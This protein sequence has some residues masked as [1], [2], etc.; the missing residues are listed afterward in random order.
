[1][2]RAALDEELRSL[3]LARL[4]TG[5]AVGVALQLGFW[6]LDLVVIPERRWLF[7]GLRVGLL[8]VVT[9]AALACRAAASLRA[10]RAWLLVGTLAMGAVVTTMTVFL[11]GFGAFYTYFVPL[12][13]FSMAVVVAWSARDAALC[14]GGSLASYLAGNAVL[15]ARGTGTAGEALG[16][17]LF[18]GTAV[19]FAFLTALFNER[20]T[21]P[22]SACGRS[23]SAPAR[24]C[25]RASRCWGSGRGGWPPSAG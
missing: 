23:C 22:S 12:P 19:T 14:L 3:T 5:W 13:L 1:M 2:D 18:V 17:V 4:R 11:G 9:A 21:G 10:Y 16:G 25:R 20:A 6:A 7:L 15:L 24:P 8:A